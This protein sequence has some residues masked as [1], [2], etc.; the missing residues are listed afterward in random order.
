MRPPGARGPPP[1]ATNVCATAS[2][3]SLL[4]PP[5]S[6]GQQ[7]GGEQGEAYQKPSERNRVSGRGRG[8]IRRRFSEAGKAGQQERDR[9]EGRTSPAMLEQRRQHCSVAGNDAADE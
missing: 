7:A 2:E 9:F 6:D 1:K 8:E 5:G 3:V 4:E